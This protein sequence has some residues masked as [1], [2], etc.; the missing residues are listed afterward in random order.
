MNDHGSTS[1]GSIPDIIDSCEKRQVNESA[2]N[3]RGVESSG[4]P[5]QLNKDNVNVFRYMLC[6]TG[7]EIQTA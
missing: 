2:P 3:E 6:E 4:R 5:T 1:H 7:G